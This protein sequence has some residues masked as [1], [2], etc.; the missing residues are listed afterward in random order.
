MFPSRLAPVLFGLFLSGMMSFVVSGISTVRVLGLVPGMLGA[1][2][3]GWA[4]SWAVAFPL[5]LVLAPVTRLI[6]A[7]LVRG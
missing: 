3:Q 7:R 2:M 5:V 4:A 1:W 6:V